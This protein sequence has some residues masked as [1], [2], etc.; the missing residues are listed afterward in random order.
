MAD[1]FTGTV[2]ASGLL[3]ALKRLSTTTALRYT[4]PASRVTA[5]RVQLEAQRRVK[6][7]TGQTAEGIGV[8]EM[9]NG[10]GYVVYASNRRMPNLPQWLEYGIQQGKPRSH[11]QAPNPF[12]NVAVRLELNAHER[13]ISDAIGAAMTVEGLGS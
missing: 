8:V 13:R 11:T 1:G 7:A 3:S 4:K 5:T 10:E 12:F 2:D 6:R 9:N